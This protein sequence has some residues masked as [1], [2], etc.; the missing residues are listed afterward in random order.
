MDTTLDEIQSLKLINSELAKQKDLDK[1][2]QLNEQAIE[3]SALTQLK[4]EGGGR[5][6]LE[7][8]VTEQIQDQMNRID[9]SKTMKEENEIL[10]Y[11]AELENRDFLSTKVVEGLED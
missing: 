2:G 3:Q 1:K 6:H 10:T 7:D 8:I 11:G 9:D 4:Q 5:G